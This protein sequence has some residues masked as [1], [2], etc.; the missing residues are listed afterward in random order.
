MLAR[1][2]NNIHYIL[3]KHHRKRGGPNQHITAKTYE[4]SR[5]FHLFLAVTGT[6]TLLG[7]EGI[8]QV[9]SQDTNPS[10]QQ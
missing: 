9:E 7:Q 10:W 3:V 6:S 5:L 8:S 1:L 4:M 2:L